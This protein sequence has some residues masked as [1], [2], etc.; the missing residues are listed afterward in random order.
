[1]NILILGG[2]GFIG[3]HLVDRLAGNGHCISVLD[4]AANPSP[5]IKN[6]FV[7]SHLDTS[8]L[9]RAIND[10]D[11]VCHLISTTVPASSNANIAFDIES[12]LTASI[13]VFEV[14]RELDVR[15]V[16][17]L[18]SGGTV[19][20]NSTV[21]PIPETHNLDPTSS[22]GIV[23]VAVEQY[24]RMYEQLYDFQPLIVRPANVYGP[25]QNLTKPQGVIGHFLKG[26]LQ[27][28]PIQVWGD[29]TVRRDYIFVSDL[30]DMIARAIESDS[31]GTYN[32][33]AG[34]DFS[35]LQIIDTIEQVLGRGL[36]KEFLEPR[37]YDIA[38]VRLDITEAEKAFGWTPTVDLQEGVRRQLAS[39][40]LGK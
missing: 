15:K 4:L 31:T 1:M 12:N 27:N 18:S 16:V 3:S 5:L 35:V 34:V 17:Y 24:L 22:Y 13:R 40:S 32:A 9:T 20:G 6:H 33:G 14:M 23:K 8:L 29:G 30:V 2:A 36:K 21:Y 11:L 39:Y 7:G 26:A 37:G 28:Q 19:Y 10:V 25:G 38:K